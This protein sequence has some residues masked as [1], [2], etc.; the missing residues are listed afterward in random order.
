MEFILLMCNEAVISFN[1]F[2]L[3][4]LMESAEQQQTLFLAHVVDVIGGG[5]ISAARSEGS[6]HGEWRIGLK[7]EM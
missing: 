3:I 2:A 6:I 7:L 5:C 4:G 1:F